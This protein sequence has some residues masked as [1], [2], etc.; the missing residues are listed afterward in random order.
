MMCKPED[1][2]QQAQW[3][4]AAG[5]SRNHL[6]SELSS[7]FINNRS[8]DLLTL[9]K[10]SIAP[11]TMIPEHRLAVLL[12]ETKQG[13][14]RNCLYHNTEHSPS[15]YVDHL[16]DRSNFP[17]TCSHILADHDDEVWFLTFSN[18]G[19]YLA[20]AG[21][22]NDKSVYIYDVEKDFKKTHILADHRAGVCHIAWSP[23]DTKIITCSREPDCSARIWSAAVSSSPFPFPLDST[24]R[25]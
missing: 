23:D 14:I 13:W 10:E 24:D 6:L 19:R 9:P 15:L 18:N 22:S 21:A 4:G 16:C 2:K 7:E 3:D 17:S 5:I 20:T 8:Y 12:D 11:S 25:L 1:L